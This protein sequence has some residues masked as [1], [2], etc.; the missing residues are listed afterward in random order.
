[1]VVA[2]SESA[3]GML[4]LRACLGDDDMVVI[5]V[6]A[7]RGLSAETVEMAAWEDVGS[8]PVSSSFRIRDFRSSNSSQTVD[9]AVV[10]NVDSVPSCRAL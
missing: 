5:V 6:V 3:D 10:D 2:V 4:V 1:M 9:G 7:V 8:F